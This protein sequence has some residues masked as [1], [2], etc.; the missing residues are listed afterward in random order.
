MV[1][2]E[3]TTSMQ[4]A[5]QAL[6][7]GPQGWVTMVAAC[8]RLAAHLCRHHLLART[9]MAS[10]RGPGGGLGGAAAAWPVLAPPSAI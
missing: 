10:L 5:E 9:P 7:W 8:Q 4:P 2:R 1:L 6:G 3:M